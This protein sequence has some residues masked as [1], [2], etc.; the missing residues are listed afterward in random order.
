MAALHLLL[1]A[2]TKTDTKD[3]FCRVLRIK[4]SKSAKH[5]VSLVFCILFIPN[6][7]LEAGGTHTSAHRF[8][9]PDGQDEYR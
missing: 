2:E 1:K 8:Y 3:P 5:S 7:P 9:C 4:C 6:L